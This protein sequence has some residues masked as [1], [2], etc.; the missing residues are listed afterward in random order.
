MKKY[1]FP[2]AAGLLA[3]AACS[4]D[5]IKVADPVCQITSPAEGSEIYV[6][7]PFT[8]AAEGEV[9]GGAKSRAY[10]LRSTAR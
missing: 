10:R 3:F 1:L 5:E 2:V 6:Y 7:Q 4:D 8:I 9:P